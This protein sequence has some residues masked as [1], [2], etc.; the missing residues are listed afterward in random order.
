MP[1]TAQVCGLPLHG[2]WQQPALEWTIDNSPLHVTCCWIARHQN[3]TGRSTTSLQQPHGTW[4]PLA[5]C[6]L[7]TQTK[8]RQILAQITWCRWPRTMLA[9]CSAGQTG[10]GQGAKGVVRR[11][12]K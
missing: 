10:T 5:N 9:G 12:T 2:T 11:H 3:W 1:A 7:D 8:E 4:A 6:H